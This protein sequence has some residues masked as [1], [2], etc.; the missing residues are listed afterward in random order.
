[1]W[2]THTFKDGDGDSLPGDNRL[3]ATVIAPQLL[4]I[5]PDKIFGLTYG[6]HLLTTIFSLDVD[7]DL[8]FE[9]GRSGFG[10]ICAGPWVGSSFKPTANSTFFWNLEFDTFFPT[11]RY[12]KRK[13]VNPSANYF[14]LN[15]WVNFTWLLPQ[16]FELTSRIHY[17]YNTTNHDYRLP[18]LDQDL[19][20]QP[21]TAFHFNYT[22]TKTFFSENFRLGAS[23]YFLKQ[24]TD[25]D[26]EGHDVPNSKER[27]FAIGP[28]ATLI[29]NGTY[30][31]L[32]TMFESNVK[33]RPKGT[34]TVFRIVYKLK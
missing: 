26:I 8:G 3:D 20:M 31:C 9:S 2:N 21:G 22:V 27:V 32:S 33:N 24:L 34:K 16:G 23:G 18:G 12:D 19:D 30:F 25:D 6:F 4:F 15:P 1:M 28:V 11:G 14:T 17:A 10:D 29:R 5:S 7:S 13:A